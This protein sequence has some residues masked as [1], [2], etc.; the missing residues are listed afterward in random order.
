MTA[1]VL[2]GLT[3]KTRTFQLGEVKAE[4]ITPGF[5][6]ECICYS[7]NA[8]TTDLGILTESSNDKTGGK[9]TFCNMDGELT[10]TVAIGGC[11][12]ETDGIIR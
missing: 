7:T 11:G 5:C 3:K 4:H 8:A 9:G 2:Q 12:E 1:F 6:K 10:K